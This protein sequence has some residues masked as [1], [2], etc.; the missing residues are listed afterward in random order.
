MNEKNNAKHLPLLLPVLIATIITG[1]LAGGGGLLEA[2]ASATKRTSA[3]EEKTAGTTTYLVSD[4]EDRDRSRP[5]HYADCTKYA[6]IST[7]AD[8]FVG[9]RAFLVRKKFN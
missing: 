8:R 4:P 6:R 2:H 3:A 7:D 1:P 5:I 9:E